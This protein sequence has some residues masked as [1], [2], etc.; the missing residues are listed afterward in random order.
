MNP[1]I[2]L[3]FSLGLVFTILALFLFFYDEMKDREFKKNH[4]MVAYTTC[5]IFSCF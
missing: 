5:A 4:G 2:L 1:I 3:L